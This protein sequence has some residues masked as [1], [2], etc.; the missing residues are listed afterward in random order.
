MVWS[1]KILVVD[2]SSD[3]RDLLSWMLATSGFQ[4]ITAEDG[5]SGLTMAEAERPDLIITDISM[6]RLDGIEM[7][8][9]LR[10]QLQFSKVPILVISAYGSGITG[11]ALDAG[12]DEAMH[13][14]V[15]FNS[16][17]NHVNQLLA[18]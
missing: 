8:I 18:A 1:G 2:D 13:K 11:D 12:A 6:P 7:I 5:L 16:L 3:V 17:I 10:K 15:D 4:V 9:R 14:P